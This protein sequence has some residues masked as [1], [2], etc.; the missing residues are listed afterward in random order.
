M[1]S[2]W[3]AMGAVTAG[4]AVA[5]GAFGA[6]GLKPRIT[7]ELMEVFET[8]VRYHMYH[9]LALLSVGW[10]AMRWPGNWVQVAGWS[11]TFGIVVF[12]GSLYLLAMTGLGWLGAITPIG[13]V[14]FL[15]GW[16]ALAIS[17]L[18]GVKTFI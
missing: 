3:F 10:G 15:I 16:A 17:A 9:A 11:F 8:G 12:S 13:G 2:G 14:A 1:G 5:L 18:R 6:H 4:L 7:P